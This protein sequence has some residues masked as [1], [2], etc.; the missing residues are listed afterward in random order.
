MPNNASLAER[1]WEEF[2]RKNQEYVGQRML[3][4]SHF[5]RQFD[6]F[7]IHKVWY[8]EDKDD[9]EPCIIISFKE[10]ETI[11]SKEGIKKLTKVRQSIKADSGVRIDEF[12]IDIKVRLSDISRQCIVGRKKEEKQTKEGERCLLM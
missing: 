10:S 2:E 7:S 5:V 11:W 9:G 8:D 6:V 12:R 4:S 1:N 3:I